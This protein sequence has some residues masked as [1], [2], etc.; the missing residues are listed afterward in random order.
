[1]RKIVWNG[2]DTYIEVER[3]TRQG[4]DFDG[5]FLY[6]N[7]NKWEAFEVVEVFAADLPKDADD[8]PDFDGVVG[9]ENGK[10]YLV[11]RVNWRI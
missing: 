8:D 9:T 6:A 3:A 10:F 7:A 1:M 4:Y 11:P 5:Q 2:V